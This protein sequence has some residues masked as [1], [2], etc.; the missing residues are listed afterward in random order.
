MPGPEAATITS[1]TKTIKT[2]EQPVR[3]AQKRSKKPSRVRVMR[4]SGKWLVTRFVSLWARS[5][6]SYDGSGM[7]RCDG[8]L[9]VECDAVE[10]T[11]HG[12]RPI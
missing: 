9:R 11:V 10:G 7:V 12:E 4:L 1:A 6:S 8:E 3:T 5:S 2:Q